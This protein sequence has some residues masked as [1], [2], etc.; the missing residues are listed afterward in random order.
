MGYKCPVLDSHCAK[1]QYP[2]FVEVVGGGRNFGNISTEVGRFLATIDSRYRQRFEDGVESFQPYY[3]VCEEMTNWSEEVP[4]A[5]KLV[6]AGVQETRKVSMGITVVSHTETLRGTGGAKGLRSTIDSQCLDLYLIAKTDPTSPTG[7]SP[8]G[9]AM[10]SMPGS[11][12]FEEVD[13]GDMRPM[14]Q[15]AQ[16]A[17]SASDLSAADPRNLNPQQHQ[18]AVEQMQ[19][20]VD[21]GHGKQRAIEI[22][23]NIGKGGGNGP[24]P[25]ATVSC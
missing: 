23:F 7:V 3:L 14:A 10:V 16:A 13:F 20:L 22:T 11:K 15:L 5:A 17:L 1:G 12:E 8:S 2:P 19:S 4:N 9:R 21:Q 18:A 6:G 24:L 25:P